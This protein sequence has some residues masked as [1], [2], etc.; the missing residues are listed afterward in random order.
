LGCAAGNRAF[1][2]VMLKAPKSDRAT[3]QTERV[4]NGRRL[5]DRVW[6]ASKWGGASLVHAR[7]AIALYDDIS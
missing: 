2:K 7:H 1:R 3:H 4:D 6:T 5:A